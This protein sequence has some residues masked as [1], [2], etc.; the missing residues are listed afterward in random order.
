M[1]ARATTISE[2]SVF[3]VPRGMLG[4]WGLS[5]L[6]ERDGRKV[7]LDT[8]GKIAAAHNGD[9][10]GVAWNEIDAM[11]L[12]HGHYDHT[13]GLLDVLPR[14]GKRIKVIAHP[15]VFADK[16]AQYTPTMTPLYIGIPYKRADLEALGADFHLTSEPVWLS[17]NV[18]AS[19][20]IPMITDFESIDPGLC[21][22]VNGDVV[23]DPLRDD[24]A[25]FVKTSRGL[26]VILGCAHRGIINTLHHAKKVTGVETIHCVIGGTHLLRASELQMEMTVAMLREFGVE[27]L[28]VSHCTGMPAAIR[29]AQEFSPG[30]FFNNSGSVV[31][32]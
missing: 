16:V 18:V 24:Q 22:R 15:D 12:S 19:G 7:L 5:V 27:R 32:V 21:V 13:G 10:L 26:L 11:V 2:N 14:I 20:E 29:L 1:E 9:L 17:E 23:P 8:G 4:E 6:V 31:E 25:I 30:F 28:G 3:A